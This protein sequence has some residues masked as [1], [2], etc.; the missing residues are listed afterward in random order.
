MNK[1]ILSVLLCCT[2]I[3]GNAYANCNEKKDGAVETCNDSEKK[4]PLVVDIDYIEGVHYDVVELEADGLQQVPSILEYVWIGCPDCYYFDPLV[5]KYLDD[6]KDVSFMKRHSVAAPSWERDA[7]IS[8]GL[9]AIGRDDVIPLLSAYYIKIQSIGAAPVEADYINFLTNQGI[10][11][12]ELKEAMH[13]RTVNNTVNSTRKEMNRLNI[14][15]VPTVVVN[16]KYKANWTNDIKSDEQYIHL[17]NY[18][19]N[20]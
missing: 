20:K 17:I 16:N 4:A 9:Q 14:S 7:R 8:L 3:G 13:S 12:D 15:W 10:N 18:L 5:E 2:F 11:H 1:L 19:K 6:N